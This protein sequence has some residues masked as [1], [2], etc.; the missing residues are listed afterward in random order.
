MQTKLQ[1]KHGQNEAIN[2]EFKYQDN[3][4]EFVTSYDREHCATLKVP[5]RFV[6][7]HSCCRFKVSYKTLKGEHIKSHPVNNPLFTVFWC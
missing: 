6:S 5:C 4:G 3:R 1:K 7:D 2:N